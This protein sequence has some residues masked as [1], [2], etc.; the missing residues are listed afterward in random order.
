LES[1]H[2]V[3]RLREA[4]ARKYAHGSAPLRTSPADA[5][6]RPPDGSGTRACAR[7]PPRVECHG[8]AR[9]RDAVEG[10]RARYLGHAAREGC[11]PSKGR[12]AVGIHPARGTEGRKSIAARAWSPTPPWCILIYIVACAVCGRAGRGIVFFPFSAAADPGYPKSCS[13]LIFY[14]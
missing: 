8:G 7:K 1:Q 10:S 12:A 11:A 6:E 9:R 5:R 13:A 2:D 14:R 3:R 4:A